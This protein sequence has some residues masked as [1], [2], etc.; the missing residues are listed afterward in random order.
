MTRALTQ[1]CENLP[2][3]A[4]ALHAIRVTL[5]I[6]IITLSSTDHCNVVRVQ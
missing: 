4:V 2:T 6:V 5:A 3:A 1:V